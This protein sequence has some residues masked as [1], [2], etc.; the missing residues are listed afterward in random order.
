MP[1]N[2][3]HSTLMKYLVCQTW[4]LTQGTVFRQHLGAIWVPGFELDQRKSC[5]NTHVCCAVFVIWCSQD[6]CPGCF[7]HLLGEQTKE[8]LLG[9]DSKSRWTAAEENSLE[10]LSRAGM[11]SPNFTFKYLLAGVTQPQGIPL[12]I[13]HQPPPTTIFSIPYYKSLD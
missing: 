7:R 10:L 6:P 2:L 1:W 9:L 4:V 12:L 8:E 11:Y 3:L 5:S 13:H